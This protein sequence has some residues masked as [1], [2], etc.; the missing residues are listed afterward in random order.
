MARSSWDRRLAVVLSQV[1]TAPPR[2][3]LAESATPVARG[4]LD[5]SQ[6]LTVTD[7][8]RLEAVSSIIRC[9]LAHPYS[10]PSATV[11]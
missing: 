5:G 8:L 11:T 10:V 9:T 1:S 3:T 7:D 6:Q 4:W 2:A